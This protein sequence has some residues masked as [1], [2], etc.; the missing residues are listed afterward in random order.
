MLDSAV[1]KLMKYLL[2]INLIN[3][4]SHGKCIN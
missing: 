3:A 1:H 4:E 2:Y